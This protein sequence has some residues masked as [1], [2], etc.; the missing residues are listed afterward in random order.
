MNHRTALTFCVL[1]SFALAGCSGNATLHGKVTFE[2]G[3]PLTVGTV[4]FTSENGLSRGTIRPDGT[5]QIGTLKFAD[6]LPPGQYR[7]YI[8]GALEQTGDTNEQ[9]DRTGVRVPVI[10]TR[11]LIDPQFAAAESTPLTCDVPAP[12]NRFDITVTPFGGNR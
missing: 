5:Y 4:N 9:R 1:F 6:G 10:T 12:Q 11:P 8:S 7:V 3:T 2:D